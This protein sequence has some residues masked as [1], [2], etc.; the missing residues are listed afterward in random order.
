[1]LIEHAFE[2]LL[3]ILSIYK[4]AFELVGVLFVTVYSFSEFP[5]CAVNDCRRPIAS[6]FLF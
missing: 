4:L 5:V 1:M 6:G 2:A 3:K